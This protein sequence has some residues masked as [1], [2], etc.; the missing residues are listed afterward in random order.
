MSG[1]Y[2]FVAFWQQICQNDR[3]N[4]D[5][6]AKLIPR[7][8]IPPEEE[9]F[10]LFGP[11]GTGKTTWLKKK[12]PNALWINLLD[13]QEERKFSMHPELLRELIEGNPSTKI[14]VI[15]EVQKL[16]ILLDVVHGLIEEKKGLQFILTGSSARKLRREGVNLLAGRALWKNFHPFTFF[17]LGKQA[18]LE[19]ALKTGLIPLVWSSKSRE[20][21]LQSYVNLYLQEEV[22]AEAL[23]RQIGDFSRF[24]EAMAYSH[25]SILNLSNVSRECEVPRKTAESHLQILKDLLLGYTLNVF[26]HRAKRKLASHPKFYYFDPGV[27]RVLRKEG[28]LDKSTEI[29][30]AALEGIVAEHLRHWADTQKERHELT[31]W[32]TRSGLEVDFILYGPKIFIAI[33][34]KNSTKI[35]P[36][37]LSG[38]AAFTKDYP[39][40]TPFLLYRGNETIKKGKCLC[41]PVEQFLK[42]LFQ[43]SDHLSLM[44][45]GFD[46]N[47]ERALE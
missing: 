29:E 8:F 16:P 23:V 34:V 44:E 20:E 30:G 2:N 13:P 14:I 40:A 42:S 45:K 32:R 1:L 18:N 5:G 12:Y 19:Q 36:K 4:G 37:D 22:K 17:E 28:F 3:K 41:L 21:K 25:G 26:E 6:G 47:S 31:F 35:S 7:S 46:K 10:F 39:E 43:N 33:E 15:D 38:L 24:L 27:F 9:S 11:R